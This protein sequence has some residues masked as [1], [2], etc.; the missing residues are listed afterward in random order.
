MAGHVAD[1]SI[2]VASPH[3]GSS[4]TPDRGPTRPVTPHLAGAR[5][6]TAFRRSAGS[7]AGQTL[8]VLVLFMVS[9]I[10]VAGLVIDVGGWYLQ[11][12]QVQAAADAGALAGASQLPAGWSY[13]QPVAQSEYGKNG[14]GGDGA[15]V[16]NTTDLA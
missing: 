9:L 13:A 8:P 11:K 2:D 4:K 3:R 15:A 7:Q 1:R 16:T 12:Q 14:K 10:G 6:G 5:A